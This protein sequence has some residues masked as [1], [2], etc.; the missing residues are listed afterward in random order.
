MVWHLHN[1]FKKNSS[2]HKNTNLCACQKLSTQSWEK[3]FPMHIT[4]STQTSSDKNKHDFHLHEYAQRRTQIY[5]PMTNQTKVIWMIKPSSSDP[6]KGKITHLLMTFPRQHK[7]MKANKAQA[8]CTRQ[9]MKVPAQ[10]KPHSSELYKLNNSFQ[11]LCVNWSFLELHRSHVCPALAIQIPQ[12]LK[13]L[14]SST[15]CLQTFKE[16]E[17]S[18]T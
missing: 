7:K 17:P 8:K 9:F 6:I 10:E 14:C 15:H 5:R 1:S 13:E 16:I 18:M 11:D 12:L 2:L 3:P 4:Y